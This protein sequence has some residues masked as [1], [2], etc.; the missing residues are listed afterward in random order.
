MSKFQNAITIVV[1]IGMFSLRN[2]SKCDGF[3][4][5]CLENDSCPV[6]RRPNHIFMLSSR[7]A[8]KRAVQ[9]KIQTF[10]KGGRS[11]GPIARE[12]VCSDSSKNGVAT[13]IKE[14]N[15][16]PQHP[17]LLKLVI[18]SQK[19][20]ISNYQID[21]DRDQLKIQKLTAQLAKA[22][23]LIKSRDDYATLQKQCESGYQA[24]LKAGE[25]KV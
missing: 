16:E 4:R 21:R 8:H 14:L 6:L 13:V 15:G 23:D 12:V 2:V 10:N 17:D 9:G 18:S 5:L 24:G 19:Q 20:T 3:G 1:Q 7:E 22:E 25:H 11:S